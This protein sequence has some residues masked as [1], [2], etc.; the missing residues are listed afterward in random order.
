MSYVCALAGREAPTEVIGDIPEGDEDGRQTDGFSDGDDGDDSEDSVDNGGNAGV[1]VATRTGVLVSEC[2]ESEMGEDEKSEDGNDA[3]EPT[4]L[5]GVDVAADS[6]L[7]P[8]AV[9]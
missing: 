5:V 7:G 9:R 2:V 4:V 8:R 1:A 6:V 3:G